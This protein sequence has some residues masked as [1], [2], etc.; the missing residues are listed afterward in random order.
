[1]RALSDALA[2]LGAYAEPPTDAD[3]TAA[4]EAEGKEALTAR[5]ANALYGVALTHV[6]TAEYAA[7]EAEPGG[8]GTAATRGGPPA[9]PVKAPRCCCTTP[10]CGWLP[11]CGPSAIDSRSIW[12]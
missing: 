6:M 8:G 5:L 10:R 9:R 4:I 3:M 11:I 7:V 1:L 2:A 12:G